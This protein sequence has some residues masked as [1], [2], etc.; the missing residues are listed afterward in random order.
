MQLFADKHDYDN[1]FK[2]ALAN[3]HTTYVWGIWEE[4]Q[5]EV[6]KK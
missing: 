5:T 6:Y 1:E 4:D 3:A 2:L